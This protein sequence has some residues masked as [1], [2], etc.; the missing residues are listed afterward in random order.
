MNTVEMWLKA[1]N[2]GKIYEC[3]NGDMAYSKEYGLV[4]KDDFNTPWNLSAWE[5]CG[6]RGLDELLADCEWEEMNNT[7]TIK[8]AER[9]FGIVI[10]NN[11]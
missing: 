9:K 3:I 4:D 8:E 5:H 11:K 7:M 6:E 2:D 10:V 1:Q